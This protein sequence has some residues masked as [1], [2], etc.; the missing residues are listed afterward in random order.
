MVPI[1]AS[2]FWVSEPD[3]LWVLY[4]VI[5]LYGAMA[6]LTAAAGS[7]LVRDLLADDEL[8]SGNGLLQTIDRGLRLV[9]PLIGTGAY[10][11]FGPYAVVGITVGCFAMTAALLSRLEI[12]ETQP[13]PAADDASYWSELSAGFRHIFHT[14]TLGTTTAVLAVALGVVGMINAVVFPIM[15]QGLGI[16]P[17]M[18]GIFVS[19]QGVGA[20]AGGLTSAALIGRLLESR[21]VAAGTALVAVGLLPMVGTSLVWA[22][23]GMAVIGLGMPWVVVAYTTL[24]QRLTPAHL[25]GRTAAASNVAF[26]LPS[27]AGTAAAA[28]L[29]NVVD[30]R[31]MIAT[32]V[33]V[34]LMCAVTTMR[35]SAPEPA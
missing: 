19:L 6:H 33:V 26:D 3:R 1:V 10:V 22:C 2:L 8:A 11:A 35:V 29:L 17:A 27:T 9:T 7:G 24:R 5:F 20:V 4:S 21:T 23:I 30:Y 34:A 31:L 18:I 15:D 16:D 13:A 25:Q 32:A 14:P 28:A 12:I